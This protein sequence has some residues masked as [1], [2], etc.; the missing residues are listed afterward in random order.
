MGQNKERLNKLLDFID[1]LAKD[2]DNAWFVKRLRERYGLN[3]DGRIDDIY[4]YC[5]EQVIHEQA[6]QFYKSFPISELKVQL[7]EDYCRMESFRRRDNF[8]DYCLAAFQQ[9]ESITNWFCH[10]TKFVELYNGKK[11]ENSTLK[12]KSNCLILVGKL[13]VQSDYA[14]RKNTDLKDLY[15]NERIRAVLYFVY[16]GEKTTKYAFESKYNEL[17]ELYQ[18]RN[19]NHR[20]GEKNQYQQDIIDQITPNKYQYFLKFNGVL[21]DFVEHISRFLA[22]KEECGVITNVLPGAVFIKLDNGEN[23]TIDKG[24][25]FYKVKLFAENDRIYVERNRITKEIININKTQS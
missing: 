24:K 18:C 9:V 6:A 8:G 4:E 21:V 14:K 22:K 2:K 17:N 25:L 5:I 10:R 23:L 12:D 13:V 16:F 7:I 3:S 11:D 19:L 1:Q 20:G 15:F